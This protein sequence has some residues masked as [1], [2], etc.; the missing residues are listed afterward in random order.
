MKSACVF[1]FIGFDSASNKRVCA[2]SSAALLFFTTA[3]MLLE[4]KRNKKHKPFL[5]YNIVSILKPFA[6]KKN[7]IYIFASY[8]FL[9]LNPNRLR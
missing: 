6:D 7:N 5:V 9:E 8:A 4:F 1:D 2:G 3:K